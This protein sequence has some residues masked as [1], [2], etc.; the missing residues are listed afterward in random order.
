MSARLCSFASQSAVFT[1][2]ECDQIRELGAKL[3]LE[4]AKTNSDQGGNELVLMKRNCEIKWVKRGHEGWD[5]V[6]ERINARAREL[7]GTRWSF[8]VNDV[9]RIQYTS[10]GMG[11]FYSAHFDNGSKATQHRKLS[12][13]VQLSPAK[14]YVGG[15][16]R[17]WSMNDTNT[18]PKDQGSMTCFPAYLM[19][20]A[21]PVW[22]GRR[23]VLVTWMSGDDKLK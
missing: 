23:E 14:A 17:L 4:E 13:S 3:S 1:P 12:I 18:A 7:N 22:W 2:E 20:V 19:H 10:Y 11:E 9:D 15:A 8:E 16:L 5:W 6:F 21:K